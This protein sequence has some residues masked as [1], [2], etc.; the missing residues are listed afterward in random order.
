MEML[1]EMKKQIR[2]GIKLERPF[3]NS[4]LMSIDKNIVNENT[5]SKILDLDEMKKNIGEITGNPEDL[6]L[7][8]AGEDNMKLEF[9]GEEP[10]N[11]V[12]QFLNE[13]LY[14]DMLDKLMKPFLEMMEQMKKSFGSE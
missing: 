7:F 10:A 5:S 8:E 9:S 3:P 4:I 14:G 2:E 13:F 6:V 1:E 11:K 12:F